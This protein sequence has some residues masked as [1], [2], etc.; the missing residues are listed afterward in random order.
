MSRLPRICRKRVSPAW[1]HSGAS[2][3][4]RSSS[5]FIA[6]RRLATIDRASSIA[7]CNCTFSGA[8][9]TAGIGLEVGDDRGHAGGEVADL[10]E[11]AA[12]VLGALV[13]EQHPGVVGVAADRRQRLVEFVADARRHGAEGRELAGLD[14]FVLGAHQL[15]LGLLAFVDFLLQLRVGVLQ[16]AGAFQYALFQLALGLGLESDAV[17]VVTAAEGQQGK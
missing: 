12:G 14:H 2:G 16:L 1:T 13:V 3:T 4:S 11:I 6:R 9:R 8:R 17:Q 5:T 7:G 15:A 10:L